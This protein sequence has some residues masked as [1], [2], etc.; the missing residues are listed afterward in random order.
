MPQSHAAR[1]W[2]AWQPFRWSTSPET[3]TLH[4]VID[5]AGRKRL[6]LWSGLDPARRALSEDEGETCIQPTST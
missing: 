6:I 4:R 3:P 2:T 5:A 1:R